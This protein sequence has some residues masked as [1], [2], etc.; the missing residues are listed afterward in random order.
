MKKKSIQIE[1][2]TNLDLYSLCIVETQKYMDCG[3]SGYIN[4]GKLFMSSV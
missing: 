4:R 3:Q 1:N 2:L